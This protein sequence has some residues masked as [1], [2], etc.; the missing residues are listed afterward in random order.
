MKDVIGFT[1]IL[2]VEKIAKNGC[3]LISERYVGI[4]LDEEDILFEGKIT[5]FSNQ[6][7]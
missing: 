5:E 2:P 6:I 3:F 1:K 7:T 4:K